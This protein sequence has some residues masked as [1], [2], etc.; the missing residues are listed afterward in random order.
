MTEENL[1]R[2]FSIPVRI[3]TLHF[4]ERDVP[5]VTAL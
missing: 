5:C 3:R 1:S 4:D 2:L